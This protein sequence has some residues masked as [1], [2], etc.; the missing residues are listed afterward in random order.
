MRRLAA[1]LTAFA[2]VA[3]S[4]D[5]AVPTQNHVAIS[6]QFATVAPRE[7]HPL[8]ATGGAGGYQYGFSP[9]GRLSGAGAHIDAITG[10][11]VAGRDGSAQDVVQATDASGSVAEARVTVTAHLAA[12][13][14]EA[15]LSPGATL[16]PAMTGGLFPYTL[17]L[18]RAPDSTGTLAGA[19]YTAGAEG[20]VV[21]QIAVSDM[22]GD[23][24]A[25]TTVVIHVGPAVRLYPPKA[26]LAPNEELPFVALGGAPP[27]TFGVL[28]LSGGTISPT[29]T[30]VAGPS[31]GVVD[32]VT[33][34]DGN[35]MIASADILVGAALHLALS[36]GQVRPG[37]SS[38]LVASGGRAPYVFGFAPRGNRSLGTV[39]AQTGEY[40][41]G[42][43]VG[44]RDRVVV[45][46]AVG[47]FVVL[48]LPAVGPLQVHAGQGSARCIAADLNGDGR[49]DAIIVAEDLG[50]QFRAGKSLALPSGSGSVE[51]DVYLPL[52]DVHDQVLVTDFNGSGRD[53]LVFFGANGLWSLVPDASGGLVF[54]PS[55]PASSFVSPVADAY[56]AALIGGATVNRIVTSARC[57]ANTGLWR[58]DWPVGASS[59]NSSPTC[60]TVAVAAAPFAMTSADV[61]GDGRP[62]LVWVEQAGSNLSYGPLKVALGLA[63]GGFGATLSYPFPASSPPPGE[64][65]IDP[66]WFGIPEM[67][68]VGTPLGVY[69]VLVGPSS[70]PAH[71]MLLRAGTGGASPAWATG[72]PLT[73]PGGVATFGVAA[74]DATGAHMAAW[75][76]SGQLYFFDVGPS[77]P[78]LPTFS[79][80]AT[81]TLCATFTDVNGDGIPDLVAGNSAASASDVLFGDGGSRYGQRPW[82]ARTGAYGALGDLDGDGLGDMIVASGERSVRVLFGGSGQL[83]YGPETAL[84]QPVTGLAGGDLG[85]PRPSALVVDQA[86]TVSRLGLNADGTAG[87]PTT[88]GAVDVYF[89]HPTHVSV[90]DFGG[91]AAGKDALVVMENG[92]RTSGGRSTGYVLFRNTGAAGRSS[93]DLLWTEQW[94]EMLPAGSPGTEIVALCMATDRQTQHLFRSVVGPP[95]AYTFVTPWDPIAVPSLAGTAQNGD[96]KPAGIFVDPSAAATTAAKAVFVSSPGAAAGSKVYA[97]T[98]A[99]G[100]QVTITQLPGASGPVTGAVL[101]PLV[102]G[103][104]SN[105]SL[106]V[107]SAGGQVL[108]YLMTG[109]GSFSP[110]ATTAAPGVPAAVLPLTTAA[111]NDVLFAT[112]DDFVPL[113]GNG[114]GGLQ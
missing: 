89:S 12:V 34:T 40:I 45:M 59:P 83:A 108:T 32:R 84:V 74:R 50:Y 1:V 29:G 17:T 67:S 72:F 56:P 94:C 112:P 81:P 70:T 15:Y 109:P 95:G 62:D 57:N 106:L 103:A 78:T 24:D 101:A 22:T 21:D 33:V 99:T 35:G 107:V 75:S 43:N 96:L 88:L 39:V 16:T 23:P 69:L 77:G 87:A 85:L 19:T 11:Y 100:K 79:S 26:L 27:Y 31:G 92:D 5:L 42:Q 65:Y 53:Q 91:T 55:L 36:G 58:V 66:W 37:I 2:L 10:M 68:L 71:I 9:G 52:D 105:P 20:D 44:A 104:G 7:A 76:I 41:P 25:S 38:P 98:V 3:C 14:A 61:N 73:L 60:E 6:P 47:T 48:D 113:V 30:F 82:F 13:P 64:A 8:V 46:D 93:T 110:V 54:G 28:S 90:H 4:R 51:K 18:V 86:G 114:S 111:T 49:G 63:G 97:V 102:P 80:A